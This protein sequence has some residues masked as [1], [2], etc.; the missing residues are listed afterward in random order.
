[1][2][3]LSEACAAASTPRFFSN[4]FDERPIQPTLRY[5]IGKKATSP[6]RQGYLPTHKREDSSKNQRVMRERIEAQRS[7]R[8]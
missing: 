1:M 7:D 4:I 3:L 2:A 5:D 6:F 8:A